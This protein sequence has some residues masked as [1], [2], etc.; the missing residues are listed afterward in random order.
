VLGDQAAEVGA[1]SSASAEQFQRL[2]LGRAIQEQPYLK[3]LEK[4]C[5]V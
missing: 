3:R 1:T 5:N 2:L 4:R